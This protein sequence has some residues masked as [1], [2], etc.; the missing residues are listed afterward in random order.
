MIVILL[1]V[2]IIYPNIQ[3]NLNNPLVHLQ[4]L[5][6]Y[7]D[8]QSQKYIL[9]N[10]GVAILFLQPCCLFRHPAV[11]NGLPPSSALP[12]LS[13]CHPHIPPLTFHWEV[14]AACPAVAISLAFRALVR[15]LCSCPRPGL[16]FGDLKRTT[17]P[18][19]LLFIGGKWP[20][21]MK[22]MV[23]ALGQQLAVTIPPPPCRSGH[24]GLASPSPFLFFLYWF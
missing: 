8:V 9:H 16:W 23:L 22:L 14:S 6:E 18:N 13:T 4:I 1:S 21:E 17:W 15:H 3:I 19:L 5:P 12:S 20:K 24:H 2:Q 10:G 11:W 7:Q